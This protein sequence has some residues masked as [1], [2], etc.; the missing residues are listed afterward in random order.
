MAVY[1][2]DTPTKDG[3]V[4]YFKTTKKDFNGKIK[5][6]KSKKY[7][8]SEEAKDAESVFRLSKESLLRNNFNVIAQSYFKYMYT[9]RKES[10]IYCY[11]NNYKKHIQPYFEKKT[12]EKITVKDIKNWKE[13]ID[14]QGFSIKFKNNL[15][16][17]INSIFKYAMKEIGI[18]YN[19]VEIEG[20]FH[21]VK[22]EIIKEEEKIR[23]ITFEEFQQFISVIDKEND[24]LYYTFWNFMFYSGC[25]KGEAQGLK[26]ED[27]DFN[28]KYIT[29]N[30]TL[31]TKTK[32]PEGYKLTATK[33]CKN[34]KIQM[35][36]ALFDILSQYKQHLQETYTN[37]QES[38]F[39]FGNSRFL[40]HINID[41]SKE[42]YFKLAGMEEK[43]ITV[44]E[45][46]HSC[47]SYLANQ[48]IKK[49]AE[50]NIPI[51]LER[52][53]TIMAN[54]NGHTVTEMRKTY[55]HF[56]PNVQ[57]EIVNLFDEE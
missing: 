41:R 43:E 49:S 9:I 52:F 32:N 55:L 40:P 56:F 36:K 45:F 13:K 47:V 29:I 30:K 27:I 44:H 24:P 20:C 48:F 17:V 35:N 8:T 14:K 31:S 10:T 5:Q 7:K 42:K 39:V 18:S 16:T 51:D 37:Y 34:R 6:Y 23:Y 2:S 21:E 22:D 46:R 26:W 33:N 4:Y 19:P 57:D 3:R 53:F 1:K 11:E 38:W 54:R 25:R 28:N 12:I 15:Y 50:K